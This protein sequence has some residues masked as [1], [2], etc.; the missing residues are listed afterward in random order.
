[1]LFTTFKQERT[2]VTK[3]AACKNRILFPT[4]LNCIVS[5]YT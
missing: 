4:F 1:M 2:E 5:W 3:I